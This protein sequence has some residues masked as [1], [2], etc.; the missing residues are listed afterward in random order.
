MINYINTQGTNITYNTVNNDF[1]KYDQLTG[2]WGVFTINILKKS[3][4]EFIVS[5]DLTPKNFLIIDQLKLKQS[6]S[7]EFEAN[8]NFI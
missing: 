4:M 8:N 2:L 6:D 7:I 1:Y 5:I 3:I